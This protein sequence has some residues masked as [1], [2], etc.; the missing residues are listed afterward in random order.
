[1]NEDFLDPKNSEDMPELADS[2]TAMDFLMTAK[3]GVRNYAIALTEMVSPPVRATVLNQLEEAITM[4]DRIS[5]LMMKKGWLQPYQL[6]EQ[7]ALD[8]KSAQATLAIAGLTLFPEDTSR[9][10]TFTTAVK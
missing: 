3:T 6:S 9:L 5:D 10:G 1:M 7:A 2:M 4:Y 8:I